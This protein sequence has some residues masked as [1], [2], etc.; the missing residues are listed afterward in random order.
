MEST[1]TS[2]VPVLVIKGRDKVAQPMNQ[3]TVTT[4]ASPYPALATPLEVFL[5]CNN[6]VQ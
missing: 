1:V 3:S 6:V 4:L 5:W 2:S